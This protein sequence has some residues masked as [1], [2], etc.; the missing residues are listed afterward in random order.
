ML[1]T[2]SKLVGRHKGLHLAYSC[3]EEKE[4]EKL[5][6]VIVCGT[7]RWDSWQSGRDIMT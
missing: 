7:R 5:D 2:M 3:G 6:V 1:R 4:E